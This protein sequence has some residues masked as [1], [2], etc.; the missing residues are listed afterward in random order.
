[1]YKRIFNLSSL[2]VLSLFTT[3][4][5]A[6]NTTNIGQYQINHIAYNSTFLS[7]EMATAYGI[8]RANNLAVVNIS[9]QDTNNEGEGV[10]VGSVE[11]SASNLIQQTRFLDFNEVKSDDAIYY[12]S[13]YRFSDEDAITFKIDIV[14]P[15]E[16]RATEVKWQQT[17]YKQ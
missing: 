1:M 11:G 5:F 15:G 2:I 4:S 12:L 7:T 17:F 10:V 9:V 6:Q 16:T 13:E 8:K 3:L 14:L